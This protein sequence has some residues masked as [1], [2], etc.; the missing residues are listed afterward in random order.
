MCRKTKNLSATEG[1]PMCVQ[2][3]MWHLYT[4][5]CLWGWGYSFTKERKWAV[6]Q[7]AVFH[8]ENVDSSPQILKL[9]TD[10]IPPNFQQ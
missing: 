5:V 4:Y 9:M 6:N 7:T 10:T 8:E 1:M 2:V 3:C